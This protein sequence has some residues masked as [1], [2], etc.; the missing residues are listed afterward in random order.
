MLIGAL[1]VDLDLKDIET[2]K[3]LYP[4]DGLYQIAAKAK[5]SNLSVFGMPV[6]IRARESMGRSVE[7]L[8]LVACDGAF[9]RRLPLARDA[10]AFRIRGWAFNRARATTP[11]EVYFANPAGIVIGVGLAG[12][13]RKDV[14]R[15]VGD[16]R[17]VDSG[18]E[19]FVRAGNDVPIKLYLHTD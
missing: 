9:D 11:S 19:G 8:G 4:N 5:Q 16:E 15:A 2:S 3:M 7:S 17:A 13:E 6:M 12:E 10:G 14:A 1:A 18:F